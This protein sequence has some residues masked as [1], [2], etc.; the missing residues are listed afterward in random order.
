MPLPSGP[1]P[2]FTR[3]IGLQSGPALQKLASLIGSTQ[4][5]LVAKAGGG[6][7]NAVQL[8]SAICE[9]D[10]A[11]T[12]ADSVKL[13]PGYSGLQVFIANGGASS[14]QVFG[15]GNDTINGVDTATGV[16]QGPGLSALYACAD[17]DNPGLSTQAA[18][19]YR[20]LS[21]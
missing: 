14:V 8:N 18:R 10:V 1:I 4:A 17:V 13:P 7:A 15:S 5:D 16:A 19:W 20:I 2:S 12:G 11:A 3:T 21:A 6:K 9:I